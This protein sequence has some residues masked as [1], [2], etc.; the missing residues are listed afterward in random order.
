MPISLPNGTTILADIEPGS[1][2][3]SDVSWKSFS[4]DEIG[5]RIVGVAQSLDAAVRK[6][7]PSSASVEFGIELSAESG[8]LT[9]LLVKGSGKANLKITLNWEMGDQAADQTEGPND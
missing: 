1:T 4:F 9:A 7:K 6:V 2:A 3:E 8:K 5:E